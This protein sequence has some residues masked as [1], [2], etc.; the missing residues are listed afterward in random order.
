MLFIVDNLRYSRAHE[1]SQ[2]NNLKS[3]FPK[4]GAE[5][6]AASK[7]PVPH[8]EVPGSSEDEASGALRKQGKL[9]SP[10]VKEPVQL[11]DSRS[12]SYAIECCLHRAT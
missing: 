3:K 2:P 7:T 1:V 12:A 10:S 5:T 11:E 6:L 9:M 4:T 8:P